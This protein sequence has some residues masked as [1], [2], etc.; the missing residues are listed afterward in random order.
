[1]RGRFD[2]ER[3]DGTTAAAIGAFAT[4]AAALIGGI[5]LL[6][7][8]RASNPDPTPPPSPD[9]NGGTGGDSFDD[10]FDEVVDEMSTT[11]AVYLNVDNGPTGTTVNVSGEG[12][13]AN[14]RIVL[15]FHTNQIGTTQANDAG[16]FSNVAVEIPTGFA[17]FAPNQFTVTAVGQSSFRSA[18]A[19]F[20]LTG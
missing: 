13:R 19:P 11:T 1:M 5:F 8:T 4:I 18:D 20:T 7:S 10:L 12:F 2:N 17:N 6:A 14:E 15:R 16:G 9:G 3:G